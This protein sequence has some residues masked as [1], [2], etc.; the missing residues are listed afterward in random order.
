MEKCSQ[1]DIE[2]ENKI[3]LKDY[4]INK[5]R[6]EDTKD[7][8]DYFYKLIQEK[9]KLVTKY[10]PYK[11]VLDVGCGCGDYLFMLSQIFEYGCGIDFSQSAICHAQKIQKQKNISNLDFI[12]SDGNELPFDDNYFDLIYSFST[13]Y[14]VPNVRGVIKEISKKIT[15]GGTAI[16]DLGNL[17]S[18]NTIVCKAYLENAIP[19]HLRISQMKNI[20]KE[21]GFG[22]QEH[23]AFQIFPLYGR[24]PW[25]LKPLLCGTCKKIMQY[26]VN[27]KMLD[28]WI[29]NMP[30]LKN[31]AFRHIFVCRKINK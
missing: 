20:I 11:K 18:L 10:G 26:E 12:A 7:T 21:A 27:G 2:E 3:I 16:F 13:L 29:S 5:E 24:R 17:F 1:K 23:Q 31:F 28:Q 19:C 22:I 15:S 4:A 14:S 8:S 6:I 30:I 25:W 9:I